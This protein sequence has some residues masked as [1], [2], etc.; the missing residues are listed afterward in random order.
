MST[1]K[2][3][4]TGRRQVGGAVQLETL[5]AL[6]AALGG[7]EKALA[8]CEAPVQVRDLCCRIFRR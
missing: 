1:C 7:A 5:N 3:D 6:N 8:E 4:A 2:T